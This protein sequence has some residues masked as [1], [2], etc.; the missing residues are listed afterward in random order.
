MFSDDGSLPCGITAEQMTKDAKLVSD[1][2]E[3]LFK[4]ELEHARRPVPPPKQR[5]KKRAVDDGGWEIT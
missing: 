1:E 3:I 4:E 2:L 5:K